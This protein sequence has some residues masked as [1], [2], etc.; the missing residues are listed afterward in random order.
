MKKTKQILCKSKTWST[1]YIYGTKC[2][3]CDCYGYF[4]GKSS[5]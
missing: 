5:K 2:C 1:N 3:W 4:I